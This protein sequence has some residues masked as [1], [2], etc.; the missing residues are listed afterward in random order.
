[1]VVVVGGVGGA[2]GGRRLTWCGLC[3]GGGGAVVVMVVVVVVF[4]MA[5][6]V[7]VG[8]RRRK[9]GDCGEDGGGRRRVLLCGG[10]GGGLRLSL[11]VRAISWRSASRV[12]VGEGFTFH[13]GLA[14]KLFKTC[15]TATPEAL[16]AISTRDR[17]TPTSKRFLFLPSSALGKV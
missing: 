5:V 15:I 14:V 16:R 3:D 7:M 10:S 2:S 17:A 12:K 11:I 13:V 1:M 8:K 9:S 4:V 6:V